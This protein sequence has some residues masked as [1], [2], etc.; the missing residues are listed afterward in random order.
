MKISS[1]FVCHL[2]SVW[3]IEMTT[4]Y[5]DNKK[6]ET[7]VFYDEYAVVVDSEGWTK[8]LIEYKDIDVNDVMKKMNNSSRYE[9]F[10]VKP[11]AF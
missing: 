2:V 10:N 8:S 3:G 6:N 1:F 11:L 4:H 7:I 5:Y 9:C